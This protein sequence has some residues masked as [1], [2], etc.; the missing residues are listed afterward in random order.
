MSSIKINRR[1]GAKMLS[2][3]L[4]FLLAAQYAFAAPVGKITYAE[5]RVDLFKPGSDTAVPM[6]EGDEV[7]VGDAVR[8]K[9]NS[10]AEITFDDKSTVRLAQNSKVDIT[11]YQL[12]AHRARKTANI[13]VERG[14]TRTIIAKMPD[15]AEFIIST[16]NAQGKVKGSDIFTTFQSGSSGMLVAEGQLAVSSLADPKSIV[17]VP[18]GNSIMVPMDETPKDPRAYLELE[19]KLYEADTNIPPRSHVEGGTIRGVIAKLSGDVRITRKGEASPRQAG[20][21]DVLGEGDK[22]ETGA[23]GVIEIKF[24]NGNAM[25]LKPDSNVTIVTLVF[26]PQTGEYENLFESTAGRIKARIENLKGKSKFEVRTPSSICGAR[27]TIMYMNILP[28]MTQAFFEGGN[29]Y[30][31]N[32]ISGMSQVVG[33]GENASSDS[34]GNV[35]DPN[36]T[37]EGERE[38]FTEGWEPGTG[39]EGYSSP[40]RNP[41]GNYVP[42]PTPAVTPI[43]DPRS[44]GVLNP[45]NDLPF[46]PLPGV[47]IPPAVSLSADGSFSG[48]E[49]SSL[50]AAITSLKTTIER[51]PI[52]LEVLETPFIG[53]YGTEPFFANGTYS[54][55]NGTTLYSGDVEGTGT[56]G[57]AIKGWLGG[58]WHSWEGVLSTLYIQPA[59]DLNGNPGYIAGTL[60]GYVWGDATPGAFTGVG[61][62]FI[63][64]A[65][66]TAILPADLADSVITDTLPTGSTLYGVFDGENGFVNV[67]FDRAR[68]RITGEPWGIW[69]DTYTGTYRNLNGLQDWLAIAGGTYGNEGYQFNTIEGID[70]AETGGLSIDILGTYLD[71]H[72]LGAYL[73]IAL[74]TYTNENE[75]NFS[76]VGLGNYSETELSSSGYF[77]ASLYDNGTSTGSLSGLIG[78]TAADEPMVSIGAL[79]RNIAE[80]FVW[81]SGSDKGIYSY[82]PDNDPDTYTT[83]DGG[84]FVGLTGGM[85]HSILIN[86][87]YVDVLDGAMK[88]LYID[89]DGKAGIFTSALDGLYAASAG[90][91]MLAGDITSR[92]VAQGIGITAAG[93]YDSI[94]TTGGRGSIAGSFTSGG[95][96]SADE[97]FTTMSIVN[98]VAGEALN[99]GIYGQYFSGAF[100]GATGGWTA[101]IGG[102]DAIGAYYSESG[103]GFATDDGYWLADITGG[104]WSGGEL[105]AN[106]SGEFLTYT[107]MGTLSGDMLGIYNTEEGT[108]QGAGLGEWEAEELTFSGRWGGGGSGHELSS[109]YYNDDGHIELAGEDYGLTGATAAEWWAQASFPFIAIGAYYMFDNYGPCFWNT[110]INS[111]NIFKND[112]TTL[113]DAVFYGFTSGLWSNGT[114]AGS[115]AALYA[116]PDGNLGY[117]RSGNISG[118]YDPGLYMWYADADVT[119]TLIEQETGITPELFSYDSADIENRGLFG[120]FGDKESSFSG[121]ITGY[122]EDGLRYWISTEG[123]NREW[124]IFRIMLGD[125]GEFDGR[126]AETSWSAVMGAVDE[127][128]ETPSYWITRMSGGWTDNGITGDIHG[129]MLSDNNLGIIE[130]NIY[131]VNSGGLEGTWA[132]S[133]IGVW[134]ERPLLFGGETIMET[135]EDEEAVGPFG[136]YD[137]GDNDLLLEYG[138]MQG[139]FGGTQALWPA[140]PAVG[141]TVMGEYSNPDSYN[142]WGIDI[143]GWA[144]DGA[145]ILG[146]VGG[147]TSKAGLLALYVRPDGEERYRAGYIISVPEEIGGLP[148][149]TGGFY[150]GLEMFGFDGKAAAYMDTETFISPEDLLGEK[151]PIEEGEFGGYVYGDI[152]GMLA[153]DSIS[154]ADE[155][156]EQRWGLWRLGSGGTYEDELS[157]DWKAV[158]GGVETEKI[159]G[160]DVIIDYWFGHITGKAWGGNE[161]FAAVEGKDLNIDSVGAIS[162][163][164]IGVYDEGEGETGGAWEALALGTYTDEPLISSG[165]L[166][167]VINSFGSESGSFTGLIGV[168]S[169][170]TGSIWDDG[171]QF[172][173]ISMGLFENEGSG[174]FVWH[175][176]QDGLYSF[177]WNDDSYTTYGDGGGG[178]FYGVAGGRG[179]SGY[180]D[181]MALALYIDPEGSTAGIFRGDLSGEYVDL[182]EGQLYIL[183]GQWT[184]T[185]KTEDLEIDPEEF[186]DALW[187]DD[188]LYDSELAAGVG[189]FSGNYYAGNGS[190]ENLR[191]E[192]VVAG[193]EELGWGI[194]GMEIGGTYIPPEIPASIW[195]LALG[196][197][198]RAEQEG[199]MRPPDAYFLGRIR[200]TEWAGELL[201]G[202]FDGI[203]LSPSEDN[204]GNIQAG[205]ITGDVKGNYIEVTEGT[206][207]WQ[208]VNAGEWVEV[209]EL[210]TPEQLRFDMADMDDFVSVPIT[211]VYSSIMSGSTI[212][213]AGMVSLTMDLSL[214]ATSQSAVDNIWA[215]LVSGNYSG[216]VNPGWSVTVN[217]A[218][219]GDTA[220]ITNTQWADSQ[221]LANVNGTAGGNN[222]SGQAGGQYGNGELTG[223]GAGAWDTPGQE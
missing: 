170:E 87:E 3:A 74:G 107:K 175:D 174:P 180:M 30:I 103:E 192:G 184:N 133:A 40:E 76:G 51:N 45:F 169:P 128:S 60:F 194:W 168:T 126:G 29:G 136:Y 82:N 159:K 49:T 198:I 11:D 15:S 138:Y 150:P 80:P 149:M 64:P 62:V 55:P 185:A 196:G 43:V 122:Q 57:E 102:A 139:L 79:T 179:G 124:G 95:A 59:V 61:D 167:T 5:G 161:L 22:V 19:K 67:N 33:M 69:K 77:S 48:D 34:S 93:L 214:Y 187:S 91:Y 116:D 142:L 52:P 202:K 4:S 24:D 199:E 84:A 213:P 14:K 200:G 143:E 38:S 153:G 70:N 123:E 195:T 201:A 190:I 71:Y 218:T 223:V 216:T 154:L 146:C 189:D 134:E 16:P 137:S 90:A 23:D 28:N 207:T 160:K 42:P 89:P 115:L 140:S 191:L 164:T 157:D 129:R 166:D 212:L 26:N 173:F 97:N 68:M 37:P 147:N 100:S 155:V 132:A 94:F 203:W 31:S 35:S 96:L 215:A 10:K 118:K 56:E 105:S 41:S 222:L 186:K 221:W 32:I 158:M 53:W 130:G 211:E 46:N 47:T 208:A 85:G 204:P 17:M 127:E 25:N 12:D 152:S 135:N 171:A 8:T 63:M 163:N 92:E 112:S 39:T 101:K 109:I 54:N 75:V 219:A 114:M 210:L 106:L 111:Y 162:G 66:E 110:P 104:T 172:D 156:Y 27:G 151:P 78:T 113:D 119:P 193:I 88:A 36:Y 65:T 73:G 177:N 181:G 178:A 13:F 117:L 182:G 131:G 2:I 9:S 18:A 125:G 183:E 144:D 220:T 72:N 99:W 1:F 120:E 108:W 176:N 205:I 20:I 188:L 141:V 50:S 81:F 197:I 209:T 121:S 58:S 148:I 165:Y 21:N 217:G 7:S 44:P 145:V 6:R 206:G 98:S 83:Y 86:D